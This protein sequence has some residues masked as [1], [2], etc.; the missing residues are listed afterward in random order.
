LA[1]NRDNMVAVAHSRPTN[2][3]VTDAVEHT[4]HKTRRSR[5]EDT[6]NLRQRSVRF[7]VDK[8]GKIAQ[9]VVSADLAL[10]DRLEH[11]YWSKDEKDAFRRR[12][13]REAKSYKQSSTRQVKRLV[14]VYTNG[15][16]ASLVQDKEEM[17]L[18][19]KW[20]SGNGR[21]LEN[22]VSSVF[23]EEQGWTLLEIVL[24][25]RHLLLTSHKSTSDDDIAHDM[26]KFC[27]EKTRKARA[28]ATK[29]ALCDAH[30]VAAAAAA[31]QA[32][33]NDNDDDDDKH[34][35][36]RHARASFLRQ[37]SDRAIQKKSMLGS[38]LQT[39][40]RRR[41]H[42]PESKFGAAGHRHS[43]VALAGS[44]TRDGTQ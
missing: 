7:A 20:A 27:R 28:F 41:C 3:L 35:S 44:S 19:Q 34:H 29:M 1:H 26:A 14:N 2:C 39:S 12:A 37:M 38:L 30:V 42:G 15:S 40:S 21:G 23:K 31:M 8:H 5:P 25:Y 16:P 6:M 33:N 22:R 17:E 36:S 18:M 4:K 10:E 13:H 43:P 24:Y 11:V 9:Q 32:D